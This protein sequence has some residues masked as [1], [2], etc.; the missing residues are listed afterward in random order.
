[1]FENLAKIV[2]PFLAKN[3][4]SLDKVDEAFDMNAEDPDE[5]V[6]YFKEIKSLLNQ[7]CFSRF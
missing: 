1:L 7:R 3:P 4:T 6:E 5:L 2:G